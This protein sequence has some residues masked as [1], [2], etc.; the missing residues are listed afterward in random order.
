LAPSPEPVNVLDFEAIARARMEPSA[1][2]YFA[3]AAGDERT[4]AE[5]R[6]A[7]D[8]VRFRPNVL[9]DVTT[10]DVNTTILR[11]TI[12]F[13][14]ILAPTA[15]NRLGHP[16]GEL[17]VA[18]A[19]GT[20]GTIMT[21]STTASSTIEDVA[22]A[23]SGPLWFQL[24][25]YRD[26]EVT[27]SL[28]QRAETGGYRALVVTVDMPRMGSRERDTR[29][30]FV[31]PP[32]VT[33]R[34]LETAGKADAASWGANSSFA[35]YW[36][37]LL[38][39]SLTWD[40]IGWLKSLTK[41]PVIVKGVLAPEDA[42]RAIAAGADAIVVSNHGGRQ[43]DGSLATIDALPDIAERVS[44]RVPILLDGGIRRGTD[45]LK[46]LALGARAVLIGR[47]YLWGLAAD[48][49]RGVGRVLDM[50]RAELELAMA[51]A[52]CPTLTSITPSLV[53]RSHDDIRRE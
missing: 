8:R 51:L 50:L 42:E 25:V 47:P 13:P 20:A 52:G 2:D 46:A 15:L 41:L 38:D 45:V 16:D 43:L 28:V 26:R 4:L 22:A 34:N 36:R 23:A 37:N 5:N 29:N 53:T 9:V 24:Y 48:G 7:F 17:A 1:Y 6:S 11:D 19:A 30:H 33:M 44:G 31:L 12:R 3:G 35:E 32:D 39:P 49:E 27:R 18:R 10:I 40:A 14:V 21:L